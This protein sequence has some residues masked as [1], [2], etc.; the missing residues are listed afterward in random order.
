MIRKSKH[1]PGL[2][3]IDCVFSGVH[4][5]WQLAQR[6]RA[7]GHRPCLYCMLTDNSL[8]GHNSATTQRQKKDNRKDKLQKWAMRNSMTFNSFGEKLRQKLKAGN[9]KL[10]HCPTRLS[11]YLLFSPHITSPAPPR[12]PS[13]WLNP[14]HHPPPSINPSGRSMLQRITKSY[15]LKHC[16][17]SKHNHY[18][19]PSLLLLHK[20]RL[21]LSVRKVRV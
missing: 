13:H 9:T 11:G 4:C 21:A 5:L 7:L 14:H 8:W 20:D 16:Q 2:S 18:V 19:N 10:I 12:L 15:Q 3:F 1:P 17:I 6:N